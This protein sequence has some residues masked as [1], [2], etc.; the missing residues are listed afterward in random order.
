MERQVF[1]DTAI[2]RLMNEKLV[3][4]KVDREERPD[5]DRVYMTAVQAMTGSG[6]WPMSVFMTPDRQPFFGATYIPP[7]AQFNRP[8]FPDL[9]NRIDELWRTDRGKI[10]ESG[11]QVTN[12]LIS[13]S[14]SLT[15]AQIQES[16]SDT[17]FQ[18]F[19][20]HFD[21]TY[22][23]FGSG[24]KFPRPA[25]FNFL[26]RYYHR[27]GN[28]KALHITLATLRAMANGGVYDHIG[29]GFHRYSVDGQW[30]V[31]HFEKML[32]DQ[33]QLVIS[34]L[35]AY[36]IT[37]DEEFAITAKNVL[38]YVQRN[39]RDKNGGFYS[40]EDAESAFGA[41]HPHEKEEGVFYLWT[42][43]EIEQVLDP[44]EAA[45]FN[46]AYGVEET[47]NALHDPMNVFLGK[48]IL[49]KKHTLKELSEHFN[50]PF[51]KVQ[52]VIADATAKLFSVREQRPRPHLD[53]KIITA[54]NGLMISAY[55]KAYQI[56]GKKHFLAIAEQ[57]ARFIMTN[58]HDSSTH[59]LYR[60]YRDGESKFEGG[61]Q[62][63]SFLCQGL[64]D[65]Y[66]A[67]FDI[68]WLEQAI[69]L[70]QRQITLFWDS[71]N[72]GF[73]DAS[74]TDSTLLIRTKEDYDGA[75]PTGN[76]IAALNL[77]RLSHITDTK[78]WHA[79][80][81][82][83]IE[84]FGARLNQFPEGLPQMLVAYAWNRSTPKEIIIA[85]QKDTPA[86]NALLQEIHSRFIPEKLMLLADGAEGQRALEKFLPFIKDIKRLNGTATAYVCENY[87]CQLP[88]SA[89][90]DLAPLLENDVTTTLLRP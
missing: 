14:S 71:A 31:P 21:S 69:D 25:V 5:I 89:P 9:V 35:E 11:K 1:E 74:G 77:F 37:H 40:A 23:G 57:A 20:Q 32:Y 34:Y 27:T 85:G 64:L 7:R 87:A 6:G 66:E 60:R 26:L 67:S 81:E 30:R 63:Y 75:E 46:Y 47:G 62:D 84:V 73:F 70:T 78:E 15:A 13:H 58:V 76:S 79:M 22:G 42:K 56:L 39:L 28:E 53:D 83:T 88:V 50:I 38:G 48:N 12:M 16:I 55:A 29:G 90:K 72:G 33:A 43:Q 2:A 80:A 41:L 10:F 49:Y 65:L 4:I 61:L 17:A 54:W 18:L 86:T 3:C 36:Q 19:Q 8:G 68:H 44:D 59:Q 24:T 52:Q 51:E 82:K 45:I